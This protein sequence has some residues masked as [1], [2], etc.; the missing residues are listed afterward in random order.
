M[1]SFPNQDTGAECRGLQPP[2][3]ANSFALLGQITR[4]ISLPDAEIDL[5]ADSVF[6]AASST[7]LRDTCEPSASFNSARMAL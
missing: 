3:A 1:Y 6:F 5:T 4:Y 2:G 7:L